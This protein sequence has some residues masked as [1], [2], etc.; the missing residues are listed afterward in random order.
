MA[1]LHCTA[2]SATSWEKDPG[3]LRIELRI[4][5]GM[6]KVLVN[7]CAVLSEGWILCYIFICC[8]GQSAQGGDL[9]RLQRRACRKSLALSFGKMMG[10]WRYLSYQTFI[11]CRVVE[12]LCGQTVRLMSSVNRSHL[13]FYFLQA[14]SGILKKYFL[15]TSS[16][17]IIQAKLVIVAWN[18]SAYFQSLQKQFILG[19]CVRVRGYSPSRPHPCL[20]PNWRWWQDSQ[21]CRRYKPWEGL[22]KWQIFRSWQPT[23]LA[24]TLSWCYFQWC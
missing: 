3:S 12:W 11:S 6:L 24:E 21:F 4:L 13:F 14:F 1:V 2:R 8:R 9:S 23:H 20:L 17:F 7:L 18:S 22:Y 15:H 10:S 19:Q 16:Y 5:L